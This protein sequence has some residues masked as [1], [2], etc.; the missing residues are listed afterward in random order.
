MSIA[1][2]FNRPHYTS[3]A[4]DFLEQL[5]RERPDLEQRQREGRA[6][7]WD[8]RVDRELQAEFQAGRVAQQ[9]YVYYHYALDP[10]TQ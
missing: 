3:E 2:L 6:R 7:L 10:D 1:N 9:G 5:K 4:T 8:K